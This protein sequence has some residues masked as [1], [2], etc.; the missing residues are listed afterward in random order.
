MGRRRRGMAVRGLRGGGAAGGEISAG[1]RGAC[2]W[3]QR[4]VTSVWARVGVGS[5]LR[6]RWSV[7]FSRPGVSG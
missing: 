1:L 4:G 6:V 5:M 7:A 3:S 2:Q